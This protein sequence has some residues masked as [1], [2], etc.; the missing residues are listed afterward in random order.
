M[1]ADGMQAEDARTPLA[2]GTLVKTPSSPS[3]TVVSPSRPTRWSKRT[4]SRSTS[5][6]PRHLSSESYAVGTSH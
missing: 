2:D 5:L 4:P 6:S 3:S 1:R